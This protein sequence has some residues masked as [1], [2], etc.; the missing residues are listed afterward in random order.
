MGIPF[1]HTDES[2]LA[3]VKEYQDI[4]GYETIEEALECMECCIDDLDNEDRSAYR[5]VMRIRNTT[6][7]EVK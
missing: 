6:K 3:T 1:Y 4:Q 7:G 2:A 5:H